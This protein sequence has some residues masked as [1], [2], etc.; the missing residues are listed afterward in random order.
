M[1]ELITVEHVTFVSDRSF[2]A[3]VPGSGCPSASSP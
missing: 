3:F 2:Q 1:I